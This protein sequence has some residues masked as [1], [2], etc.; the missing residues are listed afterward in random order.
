ME[1]EI[2]PTDY[3]NVKLG[4]YKPSALTIRINKTYSAISTTGSGIESFN[5]RDCATLFHEFCHKLQ[6]TSSITGFQFFDLITSIWHNGRNFTLDS[7]DKDSENLIINSTNILNTYP[8]NKNETLQ[9]SK[10]LTI[11]NIHDIETILKQKYT[12]ESVSVSYRHNDSECNLTFGIGEFYESCADALER[13]FCTKINHFDIFSDVSPI[14][15]KIGESIAKYFNPQCSDYR[16]IILLLTSMQHASPHQIFILLSSLFSNPEISDVQ[17]RNLCEKYVRDLINMNEKWIGK[18]KKII[19][20]GFP[21]EDPF[22][23]DVFKSLSR[24]IEE[25]LRIRL[26]K[27]FFE[28]DFLECITVNNYK[29]QL[30]HFIEEFDGCI[31]YVNDQSMELSTGYQKIIIGNKSVFN[32]EK[33][34]MTFQC[35]IFLAIKNVN[36]Q[37]KFNGKKKYSCPVFDYCENMNKTE[38]QNICLNAPHKHPKADIHG[39]NCPFQLATYKYDLRNYHEAN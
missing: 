18:T 33:E 23:G 22:L 29:E 24:S 3:L 38:Y 10:L 34:F 4:S 30:A 8:L 26:E 14:P 36:K 32:K 17:V 2:L 39:N 12:C 1:D 28:L 11:T 5:P 6:N 9:K 31:I 27:P 37:K 25:N 20:D 35:S 16:L 15:Y 21:N 13:F 19:D 7:N